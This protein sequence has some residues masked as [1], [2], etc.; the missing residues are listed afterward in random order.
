MVL[1]IGQC[2]VPGPEGVL[3]TE[4]LGVE[5]MLGSDFGAERSPSPS[6]INTQPALV[7]EQGQRFTE[8]ALSQL[9][10]VDSPWTP[11]LACS[12]ASEDAAFPSLCQGSLSPS[13]APGASPGI[14]DA[15]ETWSALSQGET[16]IS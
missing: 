14:G 12:L 4:G 15:A 2:G 5:V 11:D 8:V 7:T 3:E 6:L 10:T 1:T 16:G 13:W 9:D